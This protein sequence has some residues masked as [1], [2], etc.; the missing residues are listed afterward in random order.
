MDTD[1]DS[2]MPPVPGKNYLGCC[3]GSALGCGLSF[4]LS[5]ILAM[6]LSAVLAPIF[7]K[8]GGGNSTIGILVSGLTCGASLLIGG[9]LSFLT[10]RLF[11]IF[12]KKAR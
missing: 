3:A 11:P 10:G 12:K 2:K 5:W 1:T 7:G 9:G 4:L 6:I 8:S